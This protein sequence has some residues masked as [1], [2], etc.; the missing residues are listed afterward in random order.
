MLKRVCLASMASVI[1]LLSSAPAMA[2]RDELDDLR[3]DEKQKNEWVLVKKDRLRDITT[4]AKL[5]DGKSIRSFKIE[6]IA[7][8]NL[9]TIARVHFDVA[10]IK[11][12]YWHTNESRLLK[13]VSNKEY[14]YY[15]ILNSPFTVPDRDVII[16]TVIEP[17]T[18]KRGYMAMTQKAVPNFMPEQPGMVRV[19]ALNYSL[20]FT[21]IDKETTRID[22]EGYGHPGGVMPAWSINFVQRSVPYITML[23]L[24]RMLRLPEYRESKEPLEFTY[25]E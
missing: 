24:A 14:Y 7:K 23:G 8:A 3:A 6:M 15:Q 20:K 9:E 22:V 2:A 25:M 17:Y 12:W 21:P 16:H 4:W 1:L 5:E 19:L 18:A 10:N 11:R 13:K